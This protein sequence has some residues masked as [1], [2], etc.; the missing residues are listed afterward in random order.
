MGVVL[1]AERDVRIVDVDDSMIRDGHPVRVPGQILQ[2]VFGPTKRWL[3]V[4]H[5]VVAE[6]GA[7]ERMER[8]LVAAYRLAAVLNDRLQ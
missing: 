2:Y 5:P 1:S 8:P 3:G 4:D 6:Q 7:Q